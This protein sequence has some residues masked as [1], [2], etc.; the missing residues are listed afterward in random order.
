MCHLTSCHDDHSLHCSHHSHHHPHSPHLLHHHH[1]HSGQHLSLQ[2]QQQQQ[3]QPFPPAPAPPPH[4][5]LSKLITSERNSLSFCCSSNDSSNSGQEEESQ[6]LP[7]VQQQQQ[8]STPSMTHSRPTILRPR[9]RSLSSPIRS[10]TAEH[11]K[12]LVNSIYKERFPKATQQ[13]EE[14]LQDFIDEQLKVEFDRDIASDAV[15]RFAHHQ[16]VE[17]TKDCYHKS[18]DKLIT[19]Q[20]FYEMYENLEK[21][22]AEVSVAVVVW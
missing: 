1:P 14:R 7:V 20:Y 22:L 13:M 5:P 10:P 18:K 19:T 3:P 11:E 6:L 4:L 16:V 2:V 8:C 17:L 9:S 15:F 12:V 21:L